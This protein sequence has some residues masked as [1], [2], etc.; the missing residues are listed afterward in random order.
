MAI[1]IASEKSKH[2]RVDN[3]KLEKPPT[4]KP[5]EHTGDG[6]GE[7]PKKPEL[8]P[9]EQ[10]RQQRLAALARRANVQLGESKAL[11]KKKSVPKLSLLD[12]SEVAQVLKQPSLGKE[13]KIQSEALCFNIWDFGG[14]DVFYTLHHLFLTR[15]GIY[16]FVFDLREVVPDSS[17]APVENTDAQERGNE[18]D[19][20]EYF[21]FWLNS[22]QM[23][24]SGAP[25][26]LAGTY[27]DVALGGN[28][29]AMEK[30]IQKVVRASGGGSASIVKNAADQLSFFPIDNSSGTGIKNLAATLSATADAQD[31]VHR[32]V[33]MRWMKCLDEIMA[34]KPARGEE[35][36]EK[37]AQLRRERVPPQQQGGHVIGR[38]QQPVTAP[39]PLDEEELAGLEPAERMERIRAHRLQQ[40]LG[41]GKRLNED[42]G[43][44]QA[45]KK[46]TS[47]WVTLGEVKERGRECGIQSAQEID[48]MLA[49]FHALGMIVHLTSTEALR[50]IVTVQPQWLVDAISKVIR[51]GRIHHFEQAEISKARLGKDVK[52][53]FD[54]ALVSQDLLEFLWKENGQSVFL[55][56]LMRRSMLLS[57]WGFE[58][59]E[60]YLC[61]ALLKSSSSVNEASLQDGRYTCVFDFTGSFLPIGVY[62]RLICLCV[63][64]SGNTAGSVSPQ[65]SKDVCKVC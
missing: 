51:D 30:H 3:V 31:Y 56:D 54:N 52:K 29:E 59:E 15:H 45:K 2:I 26:V 8:S 37:L 63:A 35:A 14:Q 34:I 40:L 44:V 43:S 57:E 41:K 33:S 65:L 47:D 13:L 64:Q 36:S 22:V 61:P 19:F 48:D 10:R 53:M 32:L 60:L 42:K 49:L 21:K 27:A 18:G 39:G 24:A 28:I 5:S 23:H 58:G 46:E 9:A 25:V 7:A 12:R 62:E 55:L 1:R 38:Q 17:K 50:S 16:L 6:Q 4:A 20:S 11:P